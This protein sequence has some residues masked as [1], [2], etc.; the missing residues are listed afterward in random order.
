MVSNGGP[1]QHVKARHAGIDTLVE[2]IVVSSDVGEA[3]PHPRPFRRALS[4]LGA[5]PAETWFVGD[6]P[7]HDVVGAAALGMQTVW[8]SRGRAWP[9]ALPPPDREVAALVDL[10]GTLC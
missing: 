3:K 5:A 10:G 7:E 8:I 2:T 9:S 4:A 1:G 6:H